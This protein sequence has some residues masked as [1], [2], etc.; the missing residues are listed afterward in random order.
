MNRFRKL[1]LVEFLLIGVGMGLAEDLIAVGVVTD[2]P[3]TWKVVGIVLAVAVPF[4]FISEVVVDHP[5]FWEMVWPDR[6]KDGYPDAFERK[7]GR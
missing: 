3:I 4:A 1:R 2:D 5:K 6:D 7:A